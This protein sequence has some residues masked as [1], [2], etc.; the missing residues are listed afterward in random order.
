MNMMSILSSMLYATIWV[1]LR[2][3]M[4]QE[5]DVELGYFL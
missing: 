1:R 2:F 4:G 5:Q 3:T